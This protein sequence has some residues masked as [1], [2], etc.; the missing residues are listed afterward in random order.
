VS[1]DR[2]ALL[3]ERE[4]YIRRNLPDRVAE[5]DKLLR[6]LDGKPEKTEPAPVE[7][8]TAAPGEQRTTRRRG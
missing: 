7:Q 5:V 3:F 4:G 2:D 1:Y 6:A 8:A